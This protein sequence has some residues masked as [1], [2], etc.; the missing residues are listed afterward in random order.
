MTNPVHPMALASRDEEGLGALGFSTMRFPEE[1][2]G[3]AVAGR[4]AV[5]I[6]GTNGVHRKRGHTHATVDEDEAEVIELCPLISH[7]LD[8]TYVL[9]A[10]SNRI[11]VDKR[12]DVAASLVCEIMMD[13]VPAAIH[14]ITEQHKNLIHNKGG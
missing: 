9:E 14:G 10:L 8:R 12:K 1:F 2:A 6:D 13:S 7:G 11:G 5:G 4:D 3:M